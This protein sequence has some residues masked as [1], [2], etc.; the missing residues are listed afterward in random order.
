MRVYHGSDSVVEFPDVNHS[1]RPLDFG[2]G[3]YVTT[4]RDQA[5]RWAQRKADINKKQNAYINIYEL[6]SDD[7]GLKVKTFSDDLEEWIDFVCSCRE[8]GLGYKD[9]DV[10]KG[11]VANDKVFR[12]VDLYRAGIWDKE[13]ALKEIKVYQGYD[14]IAF[15]TQEAIDKML[16]NISSDEV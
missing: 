5:I 4:N 2:R 7:S 15:I 10:I 11:N 16:T 3:F 9:F 12:V 13:K 6:D 14:Q 1:Y 8:G